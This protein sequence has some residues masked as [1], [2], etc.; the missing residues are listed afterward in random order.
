MQFC[1]CISLKVN[2]NEWADCSEVERAK[3]QQKGG[4]ERK[5]ENN[6]SGT[7]SVKYCLYLL[8][9]KNLHNFSNVD[10]TGRVV[11]SQV[12]KMNGLLMQS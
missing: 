1:I 4:G 10:L 9:T 8:F 6:C 11:S 5:R 7:S 12:L 2:K 3:E